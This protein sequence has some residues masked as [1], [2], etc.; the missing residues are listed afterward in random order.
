MANVTYTVRQGDTLT[1]IAY[2]YNTTVDELVRLNNLENPNLIHV[3]QV[4]IISSSSNPAPPSNNTNK[5]NITLFGL[6]ADTDRTVFATWTWTRSNTEEYEVHWHYDTGNN[7]NLWF[8]GE[9]STTTLRQS[10][11]T[12]PENAIRVRFTVRPVSK[13]YTSDE[14]E[15]KYW[16]AEWSTAKTYS[17][18]SNPPV[19][20]PVPE[21][22]MEGFKLTATL[23]NLH[24]LNATHIQF[25][26]FE[27]NAHL[28]RNARTEIITYHAGYSTT[29]AAGHQYKVCCRAIRSS[30]TS[31]WSEFSENI[32]SPPEKPGSITVCR[33]ASETSVYLEWEAS[34]TAKTYEIEYTTKHQYF[35]GSS[36]TTTISDVKQCH[37]EITGLERGERYYFRVRALNDQGESSWTW[38]YSSVLLGEKPSP[39]TTW[40]STTTAII[41]EP[42]RLHWVHNSED[43]STQKRA[44]I[45]IANGTDKQTYTIDSS[46]EEDDEKTMHYDV[47]T[48]SY[49]DG[50][51]LRWRVRTA[52]ITNQYSEWSIERTVDIY[53]PPALYLDALDFQ[54]SRLET[55]TSFP[56]VI[57][58]L[59]SS[60]NQVPVSYHVSIISNQ[61][62]ATTDE[63]GN[64][65]NIGVGQ[66]V[67]SRHYDTPNALIVEM[68]AGDVD[69]HN[70]VEYTIKCTVSMD[71]G[72]TATETCN[73]TV[74]WEEVEYIPNAE[75]S[76][77]KESLV[78]Y[79]R[80]FCVD[81]DEN[82][83]DNVTL[84]I[85]RREFDGSFTEVAKDIPNNGYT[86]YTDPHPALDFAR[87]R[88]VSTDNSTGSVGYYDLPGEPVREGSIVIQWD[89]NWSNFDVSDESVRVESPWWGSMLKLPYNI[90]VS[91]N[92]NADV[93]L[94]EYI[95]RKRPVSYYGTQLGESSTMNVEIEKT[96]LNTL[97]ALRRL[98]IWTG[99][100]Y[101][102][103]PS[104]SGYW[105]TIKVSFSQRHMELV[106]PVTISVT[107][108]EGGL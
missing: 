29:V 38:G 63:I 96:D 77:D 76:I 64:V 12:A 27:D 23:D 90:D 89:E 84:A 85:F 54:G 104:G 39:P 20:P 8:S 43:G 10:V 19:T 60:G 56:F 41:G 69:L 48:S 33:A 88:I 24:D 95:G 18:S 83:I 15:F 103:E 40:S 99:N 82:I 44:V 105:A 101:V 72:L 30:L 94:V 16:V 7:N 108:V 42:L 106:I 62:Y 37:Y 91:D 36:E 1:K 86:V 59:T 107:R 11:Y 66:E 17:F 47:D 52:G 102:R 2:Q 14:Q 57:Q 87:Y 67:Y 22:K 74:A 26:V 73:F 61:L 55:L 46:E 92:Y 45:E 97:Y 4:L 32:E 93:S 21:V 70:N 49:T 51:S 58:A 6:Q 81:A 34:S 28:Y 65:K 35:D 71:S 25:Q 80:P 9:E 68:S 3:G 98:A 50:A 31:E 100:V 13:T 79:I 78:A 75:I 53:A 5:A